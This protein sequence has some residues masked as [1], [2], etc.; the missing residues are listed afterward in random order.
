MICPICNINPK[1]ANAKSCIPCSY[2]IQRINQAKLKLSK[3]ITIKCIEC[4]K[5]FKTTARDRTLCHDP[6]K[7]GRINR[8]KAFTNKKDRKK[9]PQFPLLFKNKDNL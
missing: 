8:L 3:I 2:E 1:K 9:R 5:E 7:S 4:G 6:C